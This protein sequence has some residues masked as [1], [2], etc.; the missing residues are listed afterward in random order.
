MPKSLTSKTNQLSCQ[1][2]ERRLQLFY[3]KWTLQSAYKFWTPTNQKIIAGVTEQAA[4]SLC[5]TYMICEGERGNRT[6]LLLKK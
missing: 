4:A 2:W 1:Q 6:K 5:D 3:Y